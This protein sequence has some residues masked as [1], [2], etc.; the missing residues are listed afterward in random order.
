M[1]SEKPGEVFLQKTRWLYANL[2]S[3]IFFSVVCGSKTENKTPTDFGYGQV[4][5]NISY[6]SG[7]SPDPGDGLL[8]YQ[9][10]QPHSTS[11]GS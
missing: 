9:K 7:P 8:E 1:C 3:L 4:F 5:Q 2:Q 10:S 6:Y 11:A